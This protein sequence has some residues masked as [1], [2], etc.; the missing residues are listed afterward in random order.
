[1]S[2]YNVTSKQLMSVLEDAQNRISVLENMS[3]TL[4]LN[5]DS[6]LS[7]IRNI[8]EYEQTQMTELI[9]L[10]DEG[11]WTEQK[12]KIICGR[13]DIVQ[14]VYNKFGATIHP[15]FLKTPSDVFNFKTTSGYFYKDNAVV[16]INDIVKPKYRSMLMHD[17]ITGQDPY[18]EEYDRPDIEIS[19]KINPGELLGSTDFN[20]LEIVPF[21]PGSFDITQLDVYSIQG[22]YIGDTLPDSSIPKR[23][24]KV[25]V[26]RLL[27]DQTIN[28]YELKM[29]V[30]VNYRNSNGKFPFGIKHLYFL[31]AN[32]NPSSYVVFRI[33][34]NKYIDTISEDVV[35]VDQT[36]TVNSTCKE[37]D[38]E[39]YIDWVDGIGIDSIATSKGLTNNPLVRDTRSFYIKYPIRRSV[40]SIQFNSVTLR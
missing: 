34:E 29:R 1:M 9:S 20:L 24:D 2:V 6:R 21:I 5:L 16:T 39:L 35:V 22:Y 12:S 7:I 14:G 3:A 10:V 32:F 15:Q 30:Y 18:F 40:M 4:K 26:S 25:G 11:V 27:I 17:S 33:R 28:L 36:G 31:N 19:I 23:I 37:E 8:Q 13:A 38:M